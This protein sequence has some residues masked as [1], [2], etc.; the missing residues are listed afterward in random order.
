MNQTELT[1]ITLISPPV[2]DLEVHPALI[3][4]M[5]DAHGIA[6]LRLE[7]AQQDEISMIRA[8]D[9]LREIAHQRDVPV[10]MD[11]HVLMVEKLGLDGVHLRDGARNV[12]AARKTLGADAIIGAACGVLRHDGIGA[13]E[14]GADYVSFGPIGPSPLGNGEQAAFDL[15]EWWSEMIEVPVVAEGALTPELITQFAPVTDHIAFG[16]ELWS[17]EDPVAT[18]KVFS[19]CLS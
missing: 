10:V 15:F 5:I 2:L 7:L 6:C 4:R 16:P 14:A 8:A 13:G 17:S 11:S 12:R 18:L 19:A 3:A 1:Q 9:A